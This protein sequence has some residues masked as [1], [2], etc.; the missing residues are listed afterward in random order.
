MKKKSL[1]SERANLFSPSEHYTS[2]FTNITMKTLNVEPC[3][4]HFPYM[5]LVGR[6]IIL[7]GT[8]N[9]ELVRKR[10]ECRQEWPT[11]PAS[12]LSNE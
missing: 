7:C 5:L 10:R 1:I 4:Y 9:T 6:H 12:N 8:L 3:L 11:W 2:I